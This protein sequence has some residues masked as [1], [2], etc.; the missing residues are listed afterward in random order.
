[1]KIYFS[2]LSTYSY[3]HSETVFTDQSRWKEN[4]KE[5]YNDKNLKE[6][7]RELL[8]KHGNCLITFPVIDKNDLKNKYRL[9]K[10]TIDKT[11]FI[12][13][14]TNPI[15]TFFTIWSSLDFDNKIVDSDIER[16]LKI[17]IKWIYI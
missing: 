1:M 2:S 7:A 5:Q 15:N 16:I 6:K 10:S 17:F 3:A 11:V 8:D 9:I 4:L 12:T 13:K 14:Q